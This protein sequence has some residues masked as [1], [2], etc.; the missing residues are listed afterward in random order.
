MI[1]GFVSPGEPLVIDFN[2]PK[3]IQNIQENMDTFSN[4]LCLKIW[5]SIILGLL[6]SPC[7]E[8]FEIWNVGTS[9]IFL[10]FE[11]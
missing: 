5:E 6:E 11:T 1:S 4:I 7:I 9:N 10:K 2:I 3:L 8:L